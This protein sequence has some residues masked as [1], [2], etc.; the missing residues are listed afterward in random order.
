MYFI[1]TQVHKKK[2]C[3][4]PDNNGIF[5]SKKQTLKDLTNRLYIQH[6]QLSKHYTV[7]QF[8]IEETLSI[9]ILSRFTK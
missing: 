4:A 7:K 2:N 3:T 9:K 5:N 6:C 8:Y 1:K